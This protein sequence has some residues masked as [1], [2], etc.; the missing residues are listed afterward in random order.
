M[1]NWKI[2]NAQFLD[3][4]QLAIEAHARVYHQIVLKGLRALASIAS[5]FQ[6]YT[7]STKIVCRRLLI[8]IVFLFLNTDGSKKTSIR[9][10]VRWTGCSQEPTGIEIGKCAQISFNLPLVHNKI[11]IVSI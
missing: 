4:N 8:N 2:E 10:R 3:W 9:T 5:Y 11:A 6:S 7:E 1:W